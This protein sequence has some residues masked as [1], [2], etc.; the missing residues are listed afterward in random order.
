M[1]FF[2]SRG[3]LEEYCARMTTGYLSQHYLLN[4]NVTNKQKYIPVAIDQLGIKVDP[5]HV[6]KL[7]QYVKDIKSFK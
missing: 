7:E 5:S 1:Q 3:S 6:E 4:P 2:E